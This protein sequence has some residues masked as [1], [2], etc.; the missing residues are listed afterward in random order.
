MEKVLTGGMNGGAGA[1][2][3]QL[4]MYWKAVNL[5]PWHISDHFVCSQ[6]Q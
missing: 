5:Q 2:V 3:K 4:A 6:G 1:R